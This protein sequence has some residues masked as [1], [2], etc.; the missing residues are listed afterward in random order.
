MLIRFREEFD[1]PVEAVYPFF[2]T[3][4]DWTRLYGAF[5]DVVERSGGWFAVPLRRFPFPL[6]ARITC[7]DPGRR[8]SWEFAGFWRGDGEVRFGTRPGGVVVEGHERIAI[9]PLFFLSPVIERLFLERRF[10]AVWE[11]GWRRLRRESAA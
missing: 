5:G 11:S 9:R 7:D 8:V 2:R 3:P 4:R 1:L 6:V 10:R